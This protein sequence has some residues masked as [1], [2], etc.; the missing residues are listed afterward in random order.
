M[1]N[2]KKI[3]GSESWALITGATDG[4]GKA[5]CEELAKIGYNLIMISRNKEKL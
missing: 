1:R 4:L 3:Y 2:L 5:L